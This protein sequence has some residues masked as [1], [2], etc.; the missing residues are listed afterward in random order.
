MALE[1]SQH[2][3]TTQ[4]ISQELKRTEIAMHHAEHRIQ[5]LKTTLGN[6]PSDI[7][8]QME[9]EKLKEHARRIKDLAMRILE[10]ETN[11]PCETGDMIP[12]DQLVV[13]PN[14]GEQFQVSQSAKEQKE[15]G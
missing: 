5:A 13:C 4:E 10:E 8:A 7:V 11:Q 12:C 2:H 3:M 9:Q 14:C 6:F 1:S 15:E